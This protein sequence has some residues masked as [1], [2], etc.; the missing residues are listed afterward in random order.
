[1]RENPSEG[2]IAKH[3]LRQGYL[4]M[5]QDGIL[6]VLAGQTSLD[7]LARTVDLPHI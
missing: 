4:T 2:D 7:E 5:A 3:V 1:L 6:K